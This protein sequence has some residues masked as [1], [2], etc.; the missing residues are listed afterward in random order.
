M[1]FLAANF[2]FADLLPGRNQGQDDEVGS[3][4]EIGL[5]Q[6]LMVMSHFR[7]PAHKSGEEERQAA[8]R[9]KLRCE[10]SLGRCWHP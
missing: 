3:L 2:A 9:Q 1:S 10:H 6:F 7:P 5:E 8:R 4:E